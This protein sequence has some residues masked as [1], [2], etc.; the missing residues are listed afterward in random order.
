VPVDKEI[1]IRIKEGRTIA[2]EIIQDPIGK[3]V[4]T[5]VVKDIKFSNPNRY[6]VFG[7]HFF[8]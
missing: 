7:N 2:I 5:P 1:Q 4:I 8:I 6:I 3:E